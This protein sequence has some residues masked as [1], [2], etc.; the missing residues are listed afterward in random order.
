MTV[1]LD[2]HLITGAPFDDTTGVDIHRNARNIEVRN[3]TISNPGK[4]G[5]GVTMAPYKVPELQDSSFDDVPPAI[6]HAKTAD[7]DPPLDPWNYLPATNYTLDH[8]NI[9]AGGR[10]VIMAGTGNVVRNCTIDV[11][12]ATAILS[13]GPNALIE[14]NT[15]VVH[16]AQGD[17]TSTTAA[18]KLRDADGT[19]IRNNKI[20]V[21]GGVFSKAKVAINLLAS[22][23]VVI[24]NNV[25]EGAEAL[26]RK[27]ADS[28]T[29]ESGNTVH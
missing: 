6:Y 20:V 29:V 24:E 19:I 5:L 27:D 16:Q 14:G 2:G 18:L 3:G 21:K 15:I 10:A 1:D 25:I 7:V 13:Y 4:L 8:L 23:G 9:Q 26:V 22:H 28:T 17:P 11:D 12:S